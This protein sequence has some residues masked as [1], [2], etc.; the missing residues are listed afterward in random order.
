MVAEEVRS[1]C[2]NAGSEQDLELDES[3]CPAVP[4]VERMDPREVQMGDH[5]LDE[6]VRNPHFG[7]RRLKVRTVEPFAHALDEVF[8]VLRRSTSVPRADD[9]RLCPNLA[10]IVDQ[11][12]TLARDIKVSRA[13]LDAL[14]SPVWT[15]GPD[16]RIDWINSA[17]AKAVEAASNAEVT[18]HQI[19]LLEMRQRDSAKVRIDAGET[20]RERLPLISGGE[21]KA[22]D[23]VIL[24]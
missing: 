7:A 14:P 3:R 24:K 4:V 11:Q 16:G 18:E 1:W 17:Y 22:H 2:G 9:D 10:R 19:E 21:R 12:R 6:G 5:R 13:L 23:V 8:T 20:F 15:R